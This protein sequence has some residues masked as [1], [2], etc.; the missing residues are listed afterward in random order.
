M[1]VYSPTVDNGSFKLFKLNKMYRCIS[2]CINV[3]LCILPLLSIQTYTYHASYYITVL[4]SSMHLSRLILLYLHPSVQM[5]T[6]R[7]MGLM[8]NGAVL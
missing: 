8:T 1:Y 6:N 4:H 7:I 5:E 3:T 2:A